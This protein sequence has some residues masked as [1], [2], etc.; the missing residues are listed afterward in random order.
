MFGCFTGCSYPKPP[1]IFYYKKGAETGIVL[2]V[3]EENLDSNYSDTTSNQDITQPI[4]KKRPAWIGITWEIVQTLLMAVVLYF[5]I[6]TVVGRVRVENISMQPTLHEG[7]FILVNKLAYRLGDFNRGDVVVFHYPRNPEE[8]Y[9]KRLIG[10]P[11]DTVSI[12]NG[13]VFVNNQVLE[14]PY[15]AAQ[16]DYSNVWHVPEGML[17]VL[18]DNRNQSSDSHSWGF[19]P[20]DYVV[21]KALVIYWPLEELRILN[22]VPGV[23]AANNPP[24]EYEPINEAPAIND[25]PAVQPAAP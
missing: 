3:S 9:I 8:D 6:D 18:G 23:H 5:L 20:T 21:G 24:T 4:Q 12:Q 13:Q 7:Q 11:G 10:L 1:D 17:F 2:P 25:Y 16:P 15:I 22:Q 14:E 19:V